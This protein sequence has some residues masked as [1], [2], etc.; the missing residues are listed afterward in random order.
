MLELGCNTLCSGPRSFRWKSRIY[1]P[2]TALYP[3]WNSRCAALGSWPS[4]LLTGILSTSYACWRDDT[5]GS[6]PDG[7]SSAVVKEQPE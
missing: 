4:P 5:S 6:V 3:D 2:P 7:V 1:S